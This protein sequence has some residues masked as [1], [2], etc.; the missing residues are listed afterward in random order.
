MQNELLGKII[1][2][3]ILTSL[4]NITVYYNS[5]LDSE[6]RGITFIYSVLLNL[7]NLLSMEPW[8]VAKKNILHIFIILYYIY[9]F[10]GS[11]FPIIGDYLN[12]N[13][14]NKLRFN[15]ISK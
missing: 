13:K 9:G 5:I 6:C 14:I 1:R 3:K 4:Q 8:N 12:G 2:F 15:L 7:P 10:V 11:V